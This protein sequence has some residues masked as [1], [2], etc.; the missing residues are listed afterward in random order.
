MGCSFSQNNSFGIISASTLS[1][2]N[3]TFHLSVGQYGRN[4]NT[5]SDYPV[6]IGYIVSHYNGTESQLFPW[7]MLDNSY[8][9]TD[10]AANTSCLYGNTFYGKAI[11]IVYGNITSCFRYVIYR[12]YVIIKPYILH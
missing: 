7:I 3:S 2:I 12:I 5:F 6:A 8:D 11:D 9:I 10:T 1:L 4:F